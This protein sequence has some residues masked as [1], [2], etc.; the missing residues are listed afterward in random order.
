MS[1]ISL[2]NELMWAGI[3]TGAFFNS[4]FNEFELTAFKLNFSEAVLENLAIGFNN[5]LL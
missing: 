3:W 1:F 2:Q 5:L 4:E